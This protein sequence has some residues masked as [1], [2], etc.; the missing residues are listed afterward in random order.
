MTN[1]KEVNRKRVRWMDLPMAPLT[2]PNRMDPCVGVDIS[3]G[4]LI[5][6]DPNVNQTHRRNTTDCHDNRNHINY[7]LLAWRRGVVVKSLVVSTK[8][9]YVEP[10]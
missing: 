9:L 7:L 3:P 10:G 2:V 5:T 1:L 4:C 8:L 6:S